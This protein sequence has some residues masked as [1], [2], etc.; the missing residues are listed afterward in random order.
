MM[1][2]LVRD[3]TGVHAISMQKG[4]QL[5]DLVHDHLVSGGCVELD[6]DSVKLCA[7]PFFNAS[8]GRILK[9]VSIDELRE[10][11]TFININE[12]QRLL[13]N[14]V[15]ANALAFYKNGTQINNGISRAI[16]YNFGQAMS[17]I[18]PITNP[19]AGLPDEVRKPYGCWLKKLS[20]TDTPPRGKCQK[21]FAKHRLLRL[22]LSRSRDLE[23]LNFLRETEQDGNE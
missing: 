21:F 22:K 7:A 18:S 11:V 17:F 20:P 16:E 12:P 13:I 10:R 23:V 9:D 4:N 1:K 15:I 6:F 14:H 19:L 5:F 3:I 8:V 2:I